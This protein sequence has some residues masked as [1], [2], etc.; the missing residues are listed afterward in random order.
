MSN[1][2]TERLSRAYKEKAKRLK[3]WSGIDLQRAYSPQDI[4]TDYVV[5]LGD[6]GQPPYTR[7][8]HEDMY[9]RHSPDSPLVRGNHTTVPPSR[10]RDHFRGRLIT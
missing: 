8:I 4:A 3:T 10:E 6:P 7:G 9:S 1:I 2:E 5:D